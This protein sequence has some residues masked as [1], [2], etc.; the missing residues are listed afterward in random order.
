MIF[1]KIFI[2]M[3]KLS[4]LKLNAY[5]E[6]NLE[7]KQMNALRGGTT[8]TCSCMYVDYGG[9]SKQDNSAANYNIGSGGHSVGGCNCYYYTDEYDEF[10]D[11]IIR[12]Y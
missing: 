7:N 5:R 12:G 10:L 1:L 9:S 2:E 6:Q 4:K 11:V 3:K 8:C